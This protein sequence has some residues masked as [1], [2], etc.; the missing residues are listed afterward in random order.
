MLVKEVMPILNC[1]EYYICMNGNLEKFYWSEED[2]LIEKYG[3]KE[4]ITIKTPSIVNGVE[5]DIYE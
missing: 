1:P 2:L 4:I 3:E 5:I